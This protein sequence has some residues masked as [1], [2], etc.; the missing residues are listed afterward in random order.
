MDEAVLE[1]TREGTLDPITECRD[2]IGKLLKIYSAVILLLVVTG[3]GNLFFVFVGGDGA[4]LIGRIL[5]ASLPL[6]MWLYSQKAYSTGD[7]LVIYAF[8]EVVQVALLLVL[9]VIGA[10]FLSDSPRHSAGLIILV[11]LASLFGAAL[12]LVL[13]VLLFRAALRMVRLQQIVETIN[14][15]KGI[16]SKEDPWF[17]PTGIVFLMLLCYLAPG[18][19]FSWSSIVRVFDHYSAPA[20]KVYDVGSRIAYMAGSPDGEL[21]A[22]GT[23]KGLYVWDTTSRECVWSDDCLAVQRVRFSPSGRY[24]AAAGRGRPEGASD[25]VVYE[26]E[27]FRRLS[28]FN[29]PEHEEHKE[30]VFHDLAF[31][32]DEETLLVLWHRSWIWNR[33]SQGWF[34][35]EAERIWERENKLGHETNL[36]DL[37]CTEVAVAGGEIGLPRTIRQGLSVSFELS[38]EGSAYFSSDASRFVYPTDNAQTISVCKWV[39]S[40]DTKTWEER[41]FQLDGYRLDSYWGVRYYGWKLNAEGTRAYLLGEK[42]E[43]G[44]DVGVLLELDLGTG[45]KREFAGKGGRLL[46]SSD[47][48]TIVMLAGDNQSQRIMIVALNFLDRKTQAEV[49]VLRKFDKDDRGSP[50]RFVWLKT[51]L[52]A[53]AM[54]DQ[55]GTLAFID[56][57][58]EDK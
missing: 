54:D 16:A 38:P 53:V 22:L 26:V 35:R 50:R 9:M 15:E 47:E 44:K 45:L 42:K 8:L 20:V 52:F 17:V 27:G 19:D 40:V 41:M 6:L 29:W 37:L 18:I 49:Q 34:S 55:R 14:E 3:G 46:L 48:K 25:L 24:L 1:P 30:K 4:G 12:V 58:R 33:M 43:K 36:A 10:P 56:L 28:G 23:A 11:L 5:Y 21:L 51:E 7:I 2:R 13:L 39:H 57:E 32:P 31:R